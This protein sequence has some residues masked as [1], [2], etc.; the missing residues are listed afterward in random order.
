MLARFDL[1]FVADHTTKQYGVS[2]DRPSTSSLSNMVWLNPVSSSCVPSTGTVRFSS[3]AR[4]TTNFSPDG[5]TRYAA[6]ST[7]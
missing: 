7:V 5:S 1:E 2:T 6:S 4:K 3:S